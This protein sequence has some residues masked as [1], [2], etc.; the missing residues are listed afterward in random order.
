MNLE[1]PKVYYVSRMSTLTLLATND[2][3]YATE[4]E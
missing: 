4:G 3:E 2:L 1:V